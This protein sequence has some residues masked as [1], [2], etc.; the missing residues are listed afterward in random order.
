MD[1]CFQKM[2]FRVF[3]RKSQPFQHRG[4]WNF[5]KVNIFLAK[6]VPKNSHSFGMYKG[7]PYK[8]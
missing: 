4:L 1:Q 7:D 3:S 6:N 5:D 2:G 8:K